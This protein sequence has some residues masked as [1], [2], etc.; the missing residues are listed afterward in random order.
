MLHATFILNVHSDHG[1]WIAACGVVGG[2]KAAAL[3]S[4]EGGC[5]T[6]NNELD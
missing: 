3:K 6:Q 4:K 2:K 5:P 1:S